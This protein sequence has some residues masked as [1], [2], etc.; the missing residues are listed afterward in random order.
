MAYRQYYTYDHLEILQKMVDKETDHLQ[1]IPLRPL[2]LDHR[3]R[4]VV[5]PKGESPLLL[6]QHEVYLDTALLHH[7]YVQAPQ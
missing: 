3:Q 1:L 7:P 4:A 2:N 6:S 5:L